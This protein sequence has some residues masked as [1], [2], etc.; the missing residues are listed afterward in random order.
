MVSIKYI[1]EAF[2]QQGV[3]DLEIKKEGNL[4]TIGYFHEA[5]VDCIKIRGGFI[6]YIIFERQEKL[7]WLTILD[8]KIKVIDDYFNENQEEQ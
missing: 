5:P 7:N 2:K 1:L 6:E 3:D 4:I 8:R